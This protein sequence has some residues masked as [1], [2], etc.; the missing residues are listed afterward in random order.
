M[1]AG[2]KIDVLVDVVSQKEREKKENKRRKLDTHPLKEHCLLRC[3]R[4]WECFGMHVQKD[5][6]ARRN[7]ILRDK[8]LARVVRRSV[9]GR[10]GQR[11][12]SMSQIE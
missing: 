6:L 2:Q 12:V 5:K 1:G 11:I 3:L 8:P 4:V 7:G 10:G 9:N